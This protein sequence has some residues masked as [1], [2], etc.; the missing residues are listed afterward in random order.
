MYFCAKRYYYNIN[1]NPTIM[2][3]LKKSLTILLLTAVAF[4]MMAVPAK[5]G[6]I[7]LDNDGQPL[8][9]KIIGDERSHVYVS[10]DGYLLMRDN[11]DVFRYALPDGKGGL[12]ASSMKASAPEARDAETRA[13]LS[14]IDR[15]LQL[16]LATDAAKASR[17]K[18]LIRSRGVNP[19]IADESYL[20]T[21]PTTG[22]P[23]CIAILVEFQDVKFTID[24]PRQVFSDMLNTEG[25]SMDGATGS[26]SDYYNAS[27]NGQFTPQFDV[28]GPVTLPQNMSYYG[29]N[30]GNGNDIRP[31]EMIPQA[32][33]MVN[34][35]ADF[36]KYDTDGDGV[37]DNVY[38][39]Y[40]GYGEADGGPA[41]S[42]W[43]HSWNLNDD[44]GFEYYFDGKLLNHY[45][46]SNELSSGR[47]SN[48]AGIGV[49]CHEFGH[50]MGLPDLYSTVY[51]SAFTPGNWSIMDHGSYNNDCHT[52]PTHTA[53]ERYCL[54]WIE[55]KE[56]TDPA[57]VT[58][59]PMSQI[60]NYD[61]A[62]IIRTE[63]ST[64][65]YILENRQQKSW[66]SYI[67]SHGMLVWHI[68]FVPDI[69]DLNIVNI[70]KQYIDIVEA[71]ADPSP[72]S[73]EGD[74]F[75]G[76]KNVTEFTD[77]SRPSM[78]S[79]SGRALHSPITEIKEING[80]ISFMFKGGE[81]IFDPIVAAE[82]S[83]IKAGAFT[84]SWSKVTKASG[85]LLSVY[86]K[87]AGG[88]IEYIP[89]YIKREVGDVDSYSV[90]GLTPATTYYY[91]VQATNGRFYS[92]ESNEVAVLTLDPTLD[93]MSVTA[94]PATDIQQ[95][96]FTAN[97]EPLDMADYYTVSLY[98]RQL[99]EPFTV[100]ATFDSNL[101]PDGWVSASCS[102]DS[103][104]AYCVEPPALRMT[105][106]KA[107][108]TTA[109]YRAGIRTLS[110][111]YRSNT[112]PNENNLL[113]D[114]YVNGEWMSLKVLAELPSEGTV[115]TID[116][117][118]DGCTRVRFVYDRPATGNLCIDNIVV[119][120][121]GNYELLPVESHADINAGSATSYRFQGLEAD[122]NYS[123][124]VTA[125]ND[126][127][128]SH[129]SELIA[130]HTADSSSIDLIEYDSTEP[131]V[132]YNLQGIKVD[133]PQPGNIYIIRQGTRTSKILY[134]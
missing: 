106:D 17:K 77:D 65:Y 54:N 6:L 13:M 91:V 117:I 43:P 105:T 52:P 8:D 39:F 37:I 10:S 88:Q 79:W 75:P 71:D 18:S 20:N 34:D 69:W 9:V 90:V 114:G 101:L 30:D 32:C 50:V 46:T 107:S 33:A 28:Y 83:D 120:Y 80:V 94:L 134:R 51:T 112:L 93:Y 119:G 67:P 56:L 66:D 97:W 59:Y 48:L 14:G 12:V 35:Q 76:S 57:N 63:K 95:D 19:L 44:L 47:G 102:F 62:Y 113:I 84:A 133:R 122:S 89:D 40:A 22:S 23:R 125:H 68:D 123:Y 82:A 25:F 87:T 58:M 29:V 11:S 4:S 109:E 116:R 1:F 53:Y 86:T 27:S 104:S 3:I 21:F 130:V 92:T 49:F 131:A 99:G 126:E 111:W 96:A 100:E 103:R 60:G 118:P 127:F 64:E 78:R 129:E 73:I 26:V 72:Y 98:A 31:Y 5:P 81:N 74:P 121:G 38:V 124:S 7:R 16:R 41:N 15:E 132:I 36:T 110:F 115:E 45:A 70:E 2:T 42:V 108:L 24:N 128:S 85:Y 55:P 61:D